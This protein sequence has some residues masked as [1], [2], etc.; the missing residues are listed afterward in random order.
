VT[1]S[2]QVT[3]DLLT[4]DWQ[5]ADAVFGPAA[6]GGLAAVSPPACGGTRAGT[7]GERA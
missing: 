2:G 6:D 4:V 7:L 5:V 3:P 1:A